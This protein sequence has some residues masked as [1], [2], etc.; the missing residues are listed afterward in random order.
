[1]LYKLPPVDKKLVVLADTDVKLRHDWLSNYYRNH[2]FYAVHSGWNG[3]NP[4]KNSWGESITDMYGRVKRD[5]LSGYVD[6]L[7]PK[8]TFVK[9]TKLALGKNAGARHV[10]ISIVKTLNKHTHWDLPSLYFSLPVEDF[11]MLDLEL[12]P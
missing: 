7:V 10:N 11:E 4:G 9:V 2:Q 5:N 6:L 3:R 8:G 1:M 12:A